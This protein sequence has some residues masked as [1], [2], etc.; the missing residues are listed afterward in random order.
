MTEKE[1]LKTYDVQ[2]FILPY[3]LNGQDINQ[4]IAEEIMQLLADMDYID[5]ILTNLQTK[6]R[7][8]LELLVSMKD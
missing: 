8:A 7:E 4:E 5:G 6:K 3:G 1:E 2:M